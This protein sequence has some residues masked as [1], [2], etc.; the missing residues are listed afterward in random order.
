MSYYEAARKVRMQPGEK[1]EMP[2]GKLYESPWIPGESA[3]AGNVTVDLSYHEVARK[4]K[5]Q[6]EILYDFPW[7][8]REKVL[9][10][11]ARAWIEETKNAFHDHLHMGT[12][13]EE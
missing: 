10:G 11:H 12:R 13:T 2:K 1:I 7:V 8:S 4:V 3:R 9:Q 6:K 5:E